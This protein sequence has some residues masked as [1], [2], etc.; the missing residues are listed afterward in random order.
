METTEEALR[1]TLTGL[2]DQMGA[3]TTE[4]QKLRREMERSSLTLE[5]LLNEER[6]ARIEEKIEDAQ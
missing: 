4:V 5:L 6:L 3:L 2:S 1:K